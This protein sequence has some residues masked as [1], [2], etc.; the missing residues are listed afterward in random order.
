MLCGCFTIRVPWSGDGNGG[1]PRAEMFESQNS[2]EMSE[3]YADE[4][5]AVCLPDPVTNLPGRNAIVCARIQELEGRCY[6]NR[7]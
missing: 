6:E 4:L 7:R 5:M 3:P 1:C 2:L